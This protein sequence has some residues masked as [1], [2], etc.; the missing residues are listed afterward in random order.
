MDV[1]KD[2][3][4]LL[5]VVF[6]TIFGMIFGF[7]SWIVKNYDKIEGKSKRYIIVMATAY[8]LISA[9]V[10]N[11]VALYLYIEMDKNVLI[12]IIAGSLASLFTKVMMQ[13]AEH[14]ITN[15]ER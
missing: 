9:L 5:I 3:L 13:R 11:S 7:L 10:A 6:S 2:N 14:E 1:T 4:T 8:T 15:T 12:C